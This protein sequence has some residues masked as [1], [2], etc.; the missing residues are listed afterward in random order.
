MD[1]LIGSNQYLLTLF[2]NYKDFATV[3]NE[4]KLMSN[5]NYNFTLGCS[6]TNA[7]FVN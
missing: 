1:F 2:R 5:Q 3:F 4:L 7:F 6:S